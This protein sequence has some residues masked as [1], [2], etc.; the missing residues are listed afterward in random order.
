MSYDTIRIIDHDPFW[1]KRIALPTIAQLRAARGL[2]GWSQSDLAAQAGL[3]LPTVKRAEAENGRLRVSDDARAKMR[4]ALEAAGV[5][6]TDG[7]APGVRLKPAPGPMFRPDELTS[8]D[9]G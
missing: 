3:S 8:E 2:L 5:E 1:I 9:T 7:N 6:F 4:A